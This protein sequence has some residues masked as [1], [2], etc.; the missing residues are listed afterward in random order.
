MKEI[1][2][3]SRGAHAH[4]HCLYDCDVSLWHPGSLVSK[5]ND[6]LHESL[7]RRP[8]S[9]TSILHIKFYSRP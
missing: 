4:I 5:A 6:A 3:T 1:T 2:K 9:S 8:K 7:L